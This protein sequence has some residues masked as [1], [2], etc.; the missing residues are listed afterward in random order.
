MT[1]A[2]TACCVYMINQ[3]IFGQKIE[4]WKQEYK[5]LL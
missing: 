2:R 5:Q 4:K 3:A 1:G